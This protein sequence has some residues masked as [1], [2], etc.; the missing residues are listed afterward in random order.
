MPL[1]SAPE[2]KPQ[3][4]SNVIQFP[5]QSENK[6]ANLKIPKSGSEQETHALLK[7]L[8][9]ASRKEAKDAADDLRKEKAMLISPAYKKIQ[10]TLGLGD[11]TKKVAELDSQINRIVGVIK[12]LPEDYGA[13]QSVEQP[14]EM[15]QDQSISKAA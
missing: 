15:P 9:F 4:E 2:L 11:V 5:D 7:E 1:D 13:E 6:N 8:G 12:H 10:Y 14:G 3:E